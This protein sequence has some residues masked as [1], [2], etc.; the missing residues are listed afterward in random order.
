MMPAQPLVRP[1]RA[2]DCESVVELLAL[3]H[4]EFGLGRFSP[5]RTAVVLNAAVT[6]SAPVIVGVI[7][8]DCC[9]VATIGLSLAQFFDEDDVHLEAVW[10]YVHPDYRTTSHENQTGHTAKLHRF[11]MMSADR[12]GVPLIAGSPMRAG[13]QGKIHAYCKH[14]RPAGAFFTYGGDGWK[15]PTKAPREAA[16]ASLI[17]LFGGKPA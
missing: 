17:Q 2:A 6:A 14:Y 5:S 10:D 15:R 9:I 13:S 12:L 3:R 11:A 4:S 1:V 8:G 16:A 7:D